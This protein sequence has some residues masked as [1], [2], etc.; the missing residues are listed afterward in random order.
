MG[1]FGGV[2]AASAEV[3]TEVTASVADVCTYNNSTVDAQSEPQPFPNM[4]ALPG[5]YDAVRGLQGSFNNYIYR[6]TKDTPF[7]AV[8]G[9]SS[10]SSDGVVRLMVVTA[11]NSSGIGTATDLIGTV[12]V[13]DAKTNST[14]GQLGDV[15]KGTL[16]FDFPVGQFN[17]VAGSYKGDVY[18]TVTYN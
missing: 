4:Y 18:T 7:S 12:T 8:V 1:M 2:L 10:G 17:T 9:S 13:S 16:T 6:C 5:S 15:H 3:K 11:S 14:S